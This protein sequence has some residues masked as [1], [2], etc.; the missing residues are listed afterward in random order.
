MVLLCRTKP[1]VD[2]DGMSVLIVD[3][4]EALQLSD[5]CPHGVG[6]TSEIG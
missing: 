4:R 1:R 3:M 2:V 6:V 5:Q